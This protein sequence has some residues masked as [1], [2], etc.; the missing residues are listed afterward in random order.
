MNIPSGI[1]YY[2]NLHI[3][4]QT[5]AYDPDT[6]KFVG[7]EIDRDVGGIIYI[8]NV[9]QHEPFGLLYPNYVGSWTKNRI[10]YA[11]GDWYTDPFKVI[12]GEIYCFN[13]IPD[14][15]SLYNETKVRYI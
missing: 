5:G 4:G 1:H 12:I 10:G 2:D 6:W 9:N 14:R 8:D 3:I 15:T 13:A 11:Y 7:Y